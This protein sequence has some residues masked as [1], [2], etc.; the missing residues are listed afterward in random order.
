MFDKFLYLKYA[1]L[2]I[3]YQILKIEGDRLTLKGFM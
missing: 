2:E 3:P 1:Y